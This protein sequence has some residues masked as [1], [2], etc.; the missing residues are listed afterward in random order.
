LAGVG[1]IVLS[2]ILLLAG[3]FADGPLLAWLALAFL[4]LG[5]AL[6]VTAGVKG[7]LEP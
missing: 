7:R 4:A 1:V 6:C 2:L 3:R 5:A